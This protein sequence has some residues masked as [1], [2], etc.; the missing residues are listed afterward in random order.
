[1]RRTMMLLIALLALGSTTESA[2]ADILIATAAPMTGRLAWFGEQWQRGT[3]L[4]VNDINA[5][6][7]LLG[8]KVELTFGD[9]NCDP[10]QARRA[11]EEPRR[12]RGGR[13]HRSHLLRGRDRRRPGL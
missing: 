9:D 7:G 6:G 8:Q 11:C 12:E 4:A 13:R 1:M 10:A 2:R 5:A 3:Q